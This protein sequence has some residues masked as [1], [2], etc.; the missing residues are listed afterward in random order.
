MQRQARDP[1]N[2]K[3]L[4]AAKHGRSCPPIRQEQDERESQTGHGCETRSGPKRLLPWG[5]N[6]QA[7]H[8]HHPAGWR[9]QDSKINEARAQTLIAVQVAAQWRSVTKLSRLPVDE[10]DHVMVL[11]DYS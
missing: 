9:H 1:R 5:R 8:E 4:R 11:G 2:P 3:P 10:L 6:F 7:F